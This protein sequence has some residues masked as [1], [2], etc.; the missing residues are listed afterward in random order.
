MSSHKP[1]PLFYTMAHEGISVLIERVSTTTSVIASILARPPSVA[2]SKQHALLNGGSVMKFRLLLVAVWVSVT[3]AVQ[4]QAPVPA[5]LEPGDPYHFIFVTSSLHGITADTTVPPIGSFGGLDAA[6]WVVTNAAHNAGWLPGWL[7]LEIEYTALLSVPGENAI[8]RL[9]LSAPIY[10]VDGALIA[11]GE[12]DFFDGTL[13]SGIHVDEF[14]GDQTDERVWTG[15]RSNGRVD[16]SCDD[17][18]SRSRSASTARA[19]ATIAPFS[20]GNTQSC[21]LLGHL[22]GVSPRF[23]VPFSL[24]GDYDG[25]TQVDAR[26]YAEWRDSFSQSVAPGA[27]ADGNG[28]GTIGAA[29]FVVWRDNLGSQ[30]GAGPLSTTEWIDPAGGDYHDPANWSSGV[31]AA[32]DVAGL[33]LGGVSDPLTISLVENTSHTAFRLRKTELAPVTLNLGDG[34]YTLT[35]AGGVSLQVGGLLTVDQGELISKGETLI[36]AGVLHLTGDAM[37]TTFDSVTF[38]DAQLE[39]EEG[40]EVIIAGTLTMAGSSLQLVGGTNIQA[41]EMTFENTLMFRD[42]T[43]GLDRTFGTEGDLTLI[44]STIRTFVDVAQ[45]QDVTLTSSTLW[46]DLGQVRDVSLTDSD[47]DGGIDHAR[48]VTLIRSSFGTSGSDSMA[49]RSLH[50]DVD[51]EVWIQFPSSTATISLGSLS[52]NGLLRYSISSSDKEVMFGADGVENPTGFTGTLTVS[53]FDDVKATFVKVG[54]GLETLATPEPLPFDLRVEEGTLALGGGSVV[55][56]SVA[57]HGGTL[58][59][60]GNGAA[61]R[62]EID[63]GYELSPLVGDAAMRLEIGGHD[64]GEFDVL[65]VGDF[66]LLAGTVKLAW[67]DGFVAEPGEWQV[68]N[69]LGG[70]LGSV[71]FDVSEAPLGSPNLFYDLNDFATDGIVRVFSTVAGTRTVPEPGSGCSLMIASSIGGFWGLRRMTQARRQ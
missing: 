70:A 46:G 36:D 23:V 60:G 17:W 32:D 30:I 65:T 12:A 13:V 38:T 5:G 9:N 15:T 44:N 25:N 57:V 69:W 42:F 47:M 19:G 1:Q 27:G 35:D 64:P 51:S 62:V 18:T 28:D 16:L 4:A 49:A 61:G 48:D 8:D 58:S 59:P 68:A 45:A 31:P 41:A 7:G 56:G 11:T 37:L 22:F 3:G 50:I 43:N 52:G 33:S 40:T 29:D 63:G 24:P 54:D 10:G 66:A 53:T 21:D 55:E 20:G 2:S 39:T 14:G 6:D 67:I 34:S 71:T 26:D